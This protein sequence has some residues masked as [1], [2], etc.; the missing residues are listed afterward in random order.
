MPNIFQ[1][2]HVVYAH[3][4]AELAYLDAKITNAAQTRSFDGRA[5]VCG[6]IGTRSL[7]AYSQASDSAALSATI[8]P[9]LFV[10]VTDTSSLLMHAEHFAPKKSRQLSCA[11][12]P[13]AHHGPIHAFSQRVSE[14]KSNTHP[15]AFIGLPTVLTHSRRM[16]FVRTAAFYVCFGRRRV[17]AC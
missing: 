11:Q 9:S 4:F 1:D 6:L 14:N 5:R 15:E 17:G 16:P 3:N 2:L 12:R 13:H 7:I 8:L 10:V